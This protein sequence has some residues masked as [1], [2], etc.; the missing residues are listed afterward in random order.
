MAVSTKERKSFD[1]RE[2][3]EALNPKAKKSIVFSGSFLVI[4]LLCVAVLVSGGGTSDPAEKAAQSKTKNILLPDEETTSALAAAGVGKDVDRLYKLDAG[5]DE[6]IAKLKQQ[7]EES[8][9]MNA[10]GQQQDAVRQIQTEL[11]AVRRQLEEV[12]R[13]GGGG[14]NGQSSPIGSM[15]GQ[16]GV[17]LPGAIAPAPVTPSGPAASSYGGI[18]T[19]NEE[20]PTGAKAVTTPQEK[21]ADGSAAPAADGGA[22]K[23]DSNLIPAPNGRNT[24]L[25]SGSIIQGVTLTGLDAPTGQGSVRDPVPVLIR[26]KKEAVLPNRFRS[27]VRECFVLV[28][29]VGNIASERVYLRSERMSCVRHDRTTIDMK[30]QGYVV[31]SDGKAGLRG[32]LVSKQGGYIAK[33]SLAGVADGISRAF[34]GNNNTLSLGGGGDIDT[35]KAIEG[36]AFGQASSAMQMIAEYYLKLADQAFPV[37]EV[38]AGR[39]ATLILVQGIE[40]PSMQRTY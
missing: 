11:G 25:P 8:Q 19:V 15:P 12:Q 29:G 17:Q 36:S 23:T 14:N 26:V 33:A 1:F 6:E 40:M 18:R 21:A 16:P 34:S 38:D 4:I 13:N 30:V 20:K 35:S 22:A 32:R 7:L 24:Y 27:E 9:G 28:A 3:W 31:G 2:K 5:K 39:M 37:I 10:G